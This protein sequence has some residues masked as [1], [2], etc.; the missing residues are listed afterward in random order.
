MIQISLDILANLQKI[1]ADI[2]EINF[3]DLPVKLDEILVTIEDE[4]I[5]MEKLLS[6]S[7]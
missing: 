3:N 5:D 4:S 1:K 7:Y 6:S 2:E